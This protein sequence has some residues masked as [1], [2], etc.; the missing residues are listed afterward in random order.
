LK[1]PLKLAKMKI[2]TCPPSKPEKGGVGKSEIHLRRKGESQRQ[3]L[4]AWGFNGR[5]ERTIVQREL[6]EGK[7][8]KKT[9]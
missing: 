1:K 4:G 3:I 5:E 2:A 8:G 7:G 9:E 6:G